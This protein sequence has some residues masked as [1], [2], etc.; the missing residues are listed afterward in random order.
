MGANITPSLKSSAVSGGSSI[1]LLF[2][3]GSSVTELGDAE[4]RGTLI[5][6]ILINRLLAT[7]ANISMAEVELQQQ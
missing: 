1:F 3:M 6:F 5:G 4:R 7:R 2:A